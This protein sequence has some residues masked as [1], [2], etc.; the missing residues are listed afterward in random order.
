MRQVEVD[1]EERA[2]VGGAK[3][4]IET[5]FTY[6]TPPVDVVEAELNSTMA[7]PVVAS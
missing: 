4:P 2:A 3:L 6:G 5:F 1:V 7:E